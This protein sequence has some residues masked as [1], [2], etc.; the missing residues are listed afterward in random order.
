GGSSIAARLT[1]LGW[2]DASAL[3]VLMN[4]RGLMELIALNIGLELRVISPELFAMLVLMALVTTFSTTPTLGLLGSERE[5]E[6]ERER[7]ERPALAA[8]DGVRRAILIPI[9]NP[10]GV[11]PLMD[12]AIACTLPSDP[13]LRLLSLVRMPPGGVRTGLRELEQRVAP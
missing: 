4:T 9:A 10:E 11:V 12:V 1:G 6:T 7:K 8:V 5:M 2:R 3:G 13:P